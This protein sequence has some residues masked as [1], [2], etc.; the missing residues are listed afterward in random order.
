VVVRGT[1][2]LDADACIQ[3]ELWAGGVPVD[4][5]PA[6][7]CAVV[8]GGGWELVVPLE[9]AQELR[10]GVQYMVRAYQAGGPDVVSTFP[11]DLD[12]SASE[13]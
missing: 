9:G 5:W 12:E 3:T 13:E 7:A 1:S 4:W 2:S 10:P 8:E 11:F 6:E